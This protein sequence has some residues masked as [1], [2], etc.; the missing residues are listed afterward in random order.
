[1]GAFDYT[2]NGVTMPVRIF[3]PPY[4]MRERVRSRIKSRP[5]DISRVYV[6]C[7]LSMR[8]KTMILMYRLWLRNH[9]LYIRIIVFPRIDNTQSTCYS[10]LKE[11]E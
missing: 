6:D 11:N 7:V 10:L 5:G 1:M 4:W 2:T 9:N 3:H 8:G